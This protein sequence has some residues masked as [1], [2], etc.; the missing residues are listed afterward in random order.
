MNKSKIKP[1]P[2]SKFAFTKNNYLL[3]AIGVAFIIIGT[4]IMQGGEMEDESI[5]N[6]QRITLSPILIIIG[7]IINVFAI[8]YSSKQK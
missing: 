1:N 2:N 6:F 3:L 8:L 4:F 5:F 7:F